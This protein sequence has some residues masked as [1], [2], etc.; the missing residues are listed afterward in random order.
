M[1]RL[2]T[3]PIAPA[4]GQYVPVRGPGRLLFRSYAKAVPGPRS[5]GRVATT[6]TGDVF[7]IDL[8]SV[9][10]WQLW[11]F[12]SAQSYLAELFPYLVAPG[13]R[14]LDV[15]A[16][17]GLHTVRLAKLTGALGDVIA[18]EPD[19]ELA[20][21]AAANITLNKLSNARV[22]QAAA[23][24]RPG[25]PAAQPPTITIDQVCPGPVALIRVDAAGQEAAVVAG[26]EQTLAKY[27]PAIVFCHEPALRTDSAPAAFGQLA[28]LGYQ[29]F[30]IRHPRRRVTGRGVLGLDPL[31]VRHVAG[32]DL[33]AVC[34]A[35]AA[36][37]RSLVRPA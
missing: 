9:L 7:H 17:V 36:R 37:V 30:R 27:S 21:R 6:S 26:A 4:L 31:P 1:F 23:A 33:L 18:I 28:D 24:D 35:D 3:S 12:G 11:A 16:S 10:E 20:R 2:A 34:P 8:A 15:G 5:A 14:C 13:E 22:I 29:L 19:R 25:H 32:G